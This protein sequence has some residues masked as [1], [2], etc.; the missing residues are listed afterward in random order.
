MPRE[1]PPPQDDLVKAA[2]KLAR[3][4]ALLRRDVRIL[5][6]YFIDI[7]E[8]DKAYSVP[9]EMAF[10]KTMEYTLQQLRMSAFSLRDSDKDITSIRNLLEQEGL[11]SRRK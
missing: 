6:S 11:R 3:D 10:E 8:I 1:A 4:A 2:E 7:K 9:H 5:L